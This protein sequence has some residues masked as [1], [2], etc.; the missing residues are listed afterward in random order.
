MPHLSIDTADVNYHNHIQYTNKY[1]H[2]NRNEHDKNIKFYHQTTFIQNIQQ[3]INDLFS[4]L[5]LQSTLKLNE[6]NAYYLILL[7]C[8]IIFAGILYYVLLH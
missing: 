1:R 4:F 7:G 3:F 6:N 8:L 2:E 5:T